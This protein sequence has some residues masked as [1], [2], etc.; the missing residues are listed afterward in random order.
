MKS[1][2][3]VRMAPSRRGCRPGWGAAVAIA[4]AV[5]VC[6]PAVVPQEVPVLRLQFPRVAP[7]GGRITPASLPAATRAALPGRL[8]GRSGGLA[9]AGLGPGGADGLHRRR[10]AQPLFAGRDRGAAGDDPGPGA[11]G[12]RMPRSRS[13]PTRA[14]SRPAASP[15]SRGPASPACRSVCKASTTPPCARSA[16]CTMRRRRMRRSRRPRVTSPPS[17]ST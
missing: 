3:V 2:S 8:A 16:A 12:S 13:R 15:G 6:A 4:P 10:H 7:G 14:A 9:A 1:V 17:T 5:A 11:A